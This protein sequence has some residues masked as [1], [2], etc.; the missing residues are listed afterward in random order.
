MP[1][2]SLNEASM[3]NIQPFIG[4]AVQRKVSVPKGRIVNGEEAEPGEFPFMLSLQQ[5][6]AHWCGASILNEQWGITAAH[7]LKQVNPYEVLAGTIQLKEGG[8]RYNVTE[9]YI[10]A[11]YNASDSYVNDI[12]VFRVTPDFQFDGETVAPI[13]P[14]EQG[15][16][17]PDGVNIT[18]MGWGDL[19]AGGPHPYS[20]RKVDLTTVNQEQCQAVWA[21]ENDPIYDTQL[22]V[23]RFEDINYDS[24]TGDSGGPLV[25]EGKLV[26]L[27]SWGYRCATPPY[28]SI[29]TRVS[30]YVSWITETT[31]GSVLPH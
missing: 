11:D 25:Y 23:A 19:W 3:V 27:V 13:P 28:P 9:I 31:S 17:L 12:G 29:N 4:G 18:V 14:P 10:H 26:G 6:E 16:L 5:G 7:C 24:C 21:T 22:C 20:L 1:V 15:E 2:G 30:S 8:M